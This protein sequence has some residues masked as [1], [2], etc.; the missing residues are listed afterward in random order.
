VLKSRQSI[1]IATLD[2][3]LSICVEPSDD[4]QLTLD[5]IRESNAFV[6]HDKQLHLN[7]QADGFLVGLSTGYWTF[8]K[9]ILAIDE[10]NRRRMRLPVP[11]DVSML[12]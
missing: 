6:A 11:L 7:H 8:G 3:L 5:K 2:F 10:G 4:G 9:S 12:T 1:L